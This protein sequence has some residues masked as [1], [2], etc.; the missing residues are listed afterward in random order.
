MLGIRPW[1][2][3]SAWAGMAA[4][5]AVVAGIVDDAS[6]LIGR[7]VALRRPAFL[8]CFKFLRV[9]AVNAIIP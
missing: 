7:D 4:A 3:P 6:V 9:S 8:P 5:G 1:C 2:F